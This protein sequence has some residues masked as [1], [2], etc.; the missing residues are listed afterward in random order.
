MK[1]VCFQVR[2]RNENIS[3]LSSQIEDAIRK[4]DD[5]IENFDCKEICTGNSN[6]SILESNETKSVLLI[7]GLII[8]YGMLRK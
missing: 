2:E 1:R 3:Q 7:F 8:F 4:I 5:E 6:A